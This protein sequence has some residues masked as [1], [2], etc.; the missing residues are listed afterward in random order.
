MSDINQNRRLTPASSETLFT[1]LETLPG[2]LFII[3]DAATITY[4]NASAQT[5]LGAT[6]EGVCGQPLWHGAP[7]LVSTLLYQA[8]QQTRQT[9]A[10]TEVEYLSPVTGTWLHVQ[11]SPTVGG[12]MVQVHQGRTAAL[13]EVPVSQGE[14]LRL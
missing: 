13:R 10:P 6:R 4:A 5:M 9:R 7:Q 3:D 11:L 2:A 1:L 8:V 14:C 12:L